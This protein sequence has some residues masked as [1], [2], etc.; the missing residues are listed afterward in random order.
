[1]AKEETLE[2]LKALGGAATSG[3]VTDYRQQKGE[4]VCFGAIYGDL[5][6]LECDGTLYHNRRTRVFRLR[7][8]KPKKNIV[9]LEADGTVRRLK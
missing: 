7:P 9:E 4:D 2:A 5:L 3:Q 6:K 1:M 8:G